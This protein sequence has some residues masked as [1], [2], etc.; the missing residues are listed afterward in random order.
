MFNK[1]PHQSP[2]L[3]HTFSPSTETEKN[4]NGLKISGLEEGA[5]PLAKNNPQSPSIQKSLFNRSAAHHHKLQLTPE[6]NL[7]AELGDIDDIGFSINAEL[8]LNEET[9]L[10]G[11][12]WMGTEATAE[13]SASDGPKVDFSDVP[14]QLKLFPEVEGF[15]SIEHEKL[16]I[17]AMETAENEGFTPRSM[18]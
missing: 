6:E 18:V 5:T 8:P 13:T 9:P 14:Q 16:E 1:I 3:K 4:L 12:D 2:S 7:D 15:K 11:L 10:I 17:L